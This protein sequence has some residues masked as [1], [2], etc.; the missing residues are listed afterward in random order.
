MNNIITIININVDITIIIDIV[1]VIAIDILITIIINI[2]TVIIIIN[3]IVNIIIIII[4][5]IMTSIINIVIITTNNTITTSAQSHGH[6]VRGER[7]CPAPAPSAPG[8]SRTVTQ[9]EAFNCPTPA[10]QPQYA[11]APPRSKRRSQFQAAPIRKLLRPYE[12]RI[13]FA[14]RGQDNSELEISRVFP[15]FSRSSNGLSVSRVSYYG[16]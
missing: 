15:A 16:R 12:L 8:R 2:I 9:Q 3:N 5:I 14:S 10:P 13:F 6:A 11:V 7:N 4:I 1:K